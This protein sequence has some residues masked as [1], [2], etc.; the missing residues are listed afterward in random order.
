M[1]AIL[2]AVSDALNYINYPG[3]QIICIGKGPHPS[4]GRGA[5]GESTI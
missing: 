1:T 3:K 4:Y 2:L 5:A